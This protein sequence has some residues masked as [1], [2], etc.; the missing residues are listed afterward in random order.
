MFV[1]NNLALFQANLFWVVLQTWM[2]S[3]LKQICKKKKGSLGAQV[4][5]PNTMDDFRIPGLF[6]YLAVLK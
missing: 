4:F 5:S 1:W 3:I 6:N 2:L